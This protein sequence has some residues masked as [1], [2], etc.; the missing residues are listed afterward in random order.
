MF[1]NYLNLVDVNF[2]YKTASIWQVV[3]YAILIV[4]I[5]VPLILIIMGIV[6]LMQA[7]TSGDEKAISKATASLIKKIVAGLVIFFIPIIV[8]AVFNLLDEFADFRSDFNTCLD[9]ITYPNTKCD[10]SYKGEIVPID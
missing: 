6:S 2:C 7:A 10:T 5:V 3:G 9:C 4:K 8:K 1:N